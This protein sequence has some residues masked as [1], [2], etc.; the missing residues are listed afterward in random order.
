MNIN[1]KYYYNN[2]KRT[3]SNN[4]FKCYTCGSRF[5]EYDQLY[6]HTVKYHSDLIKDEENVDKYLYDLRNPGPHLCV[7][8]KTRPCVWNSKQKHYSRLCDSKECKDKFRN[9]FS[10]KMK[11][12]YGTDNL[13]KDPERQAIM[14]ANRKISHIYTFKDGTTI[15]CVGNYEL[16][17][18]HF[19]E[20]EMRLTSTDIIPAP[21]STFVKYYDPADKRTHNYI[22]DFYIPK[23]NLVIEIKDGSK[24]PIDAK[25]KSV[26]KGKAVVKLN[27][28]NY[29]KIVDKKY[30]DFVNLI[31]QFNKNE[32]VES[33]SNNKFIF[34]I[35]E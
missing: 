30:D 25:Y 12:K 6:K 19:C 24:Y 26:L 32:L 33:K 18:M 7:I 3:K 8:C 21:P 16:D 31:D 35:P 34:I 5:G 23:Y 29:I 9:D 2:A 14:L 13:L 10:K 27:K 1:I 20:Y 15:N 11:D 4:R 17:F 28:F 22:P